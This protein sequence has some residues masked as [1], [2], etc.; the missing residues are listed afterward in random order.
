MESSVFAD[1]LS[2]L[3]IDREGTMEGNR[4]VVNLGDSNAYSRVY[5]ILDNSELVDL[6]VDNV[7]MTE[8]GGTI[9]YLSDDFDITLGADFNKDSYTLTVEE[10]KE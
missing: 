6:D 2:E 4:Y 5:T 10:A 3:G 7:S 8:D 9:V 1:F